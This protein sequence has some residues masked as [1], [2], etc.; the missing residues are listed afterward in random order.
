MSRQL[1]RSLPCVF[2]LLFLGSQRAQAQVVVL[3][4]TNLVQNT[5]TAIE[6]TITAIEAVIIEAQGVLNLTPLDGFN[7]GE[8][9]DDLHQ[10]EDIVNQASG[11]SYDLAAIEGEISALFN[12]ETAP[13]SRSALTERLNAIKSVRYESYVYAG[14]AQTIL[15]TA[16]NTVHH[17]LGLL[18]T[19]AAIVGNMG[20]QQSLG[21]FDAVVGQHAANL[22]VHIAAFNR[23]QTV[24]KLS[25]ALII[26]SINKIQDRRMDDWP[27]F[28]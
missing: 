26:E 6:S 9:W 10:L 23:A 22:D 5:A 20:G 21:Q 4:P 13:E 11:L 1:I 27:N 24:D 28:E 25:E 3:D 2:L 18:D 12:L 17:I 8:I 15:Q 16:R 7:V 14:K 19:L